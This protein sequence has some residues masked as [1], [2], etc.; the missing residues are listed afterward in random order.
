[1][2]NLQNDDFQRTLEETL[3]GLNTTASDSPL[4]ASSDGVTF[5][6]DFLQTIIPGKSYIFFLSLF[7]FVSKD[8]YDSFMFYRP[9]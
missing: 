1:M 5:N 3:K 7:V 4:A 6:F 2:A 8:I 9:N